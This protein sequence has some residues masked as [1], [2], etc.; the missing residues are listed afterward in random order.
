MHCNASFRGMMPRSDYITQACCAVS[1]QTKCKPEPTFSLC[2]TVFIK[3]DIKI[4]WLGVGV[5]QLALS[6]A[7]L[8]L[9]VFSFTRSSVKTAFHII[10]Q[11]LYL[12][13][14]FLIAYFAILFVSDWLSNKPGYFYSVQWRNTMAC[15]IGAEILWCYFTSQVT[16]ILVLFYARYSVVKHPFD[17]KFKLQGHVK[18]IVT[19]LISVIFILSV[20]IS[21]LAQFLGKQ[22]V[23]VSHYISNSLQHWRWV[24]LCFFPNI[25]YLPCSLKLFVQFCL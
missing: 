8:F 4:A 11:C 21:V 7:S 16:I 15:R 9:L 23:I 19:K 2:K 22:V 18:K 6:G 17:S 24:S 3:T 20:P 5:L 14:I 12:C 13:D 1:S 25:I 10:I